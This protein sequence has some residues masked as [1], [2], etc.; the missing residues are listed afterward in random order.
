MA[1]MGGGMLGGG[2]RN[3]LTCFRRVVSFLHIL[4]RERDRGEV[5]KRRGFGPFRHPVI[6]YL[7]L[8][9]FFLSKDPD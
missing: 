9:V 7:L 8:F 3:F 5:E 4:L 2:G 6:A 1:E